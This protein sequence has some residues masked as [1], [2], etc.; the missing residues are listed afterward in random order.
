MANQLNKIEQFK[1][2]FHLNK[3]AVFSFIFLLVLGTFYIYYHSIKD[4]QE[5]INFSNYTQIT[6]TISI[7]YQIKYKLPET[8]SATVKIDKVLLDLNY[9]YNNKKYHCNTNIA[10][11]HMQSVLILLKRRKLNRLEI[12]CNENNPKKAMVFLKNTYK[13][14][15]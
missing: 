7:D 3:D 6:K 5:E 4:K 15:Q 2:W 1:L 9:L 10:A 13:H 14:S 8:H 12:K 11:K